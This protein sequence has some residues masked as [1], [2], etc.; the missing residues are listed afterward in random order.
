[1][2]FPLH[3]QFR[4]M[5]HSDF[6]WNNIWDHAEKLDKFYKRIISCHVIVTAPH[7]HHRQGNIYHIQ[8]RLHVAGGDIFVSTEHEKNAAHED[9]YVAI[10]DAFGA[11]RRQLE[12]FAR[13]R[14]GQVKEKFS[15][16]I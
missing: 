3:I 10:R 1:M 16:I 2:N 4:G 12:D 11:T 6:I 9:V 8:I 13:K 14:R 7:H 5:D 15:E